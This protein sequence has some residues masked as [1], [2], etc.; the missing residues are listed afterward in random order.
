MKDMDGTDG[1]EFVV[2]LR[3]KCDRLGVRLRSHSGSRSR[4]PVPDNFTRAHP[5]L[6]ATAVGG[7]LKNVCSHLAAA[8]FICFAPWVWRSHIRL[9][10]VRVQKVTLAQETPA[11]KFLPA[12]PGPHPVA[13]PAHGGSGNSCWI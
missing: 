7:E 8:C 5:E 1:E 6:A 3:M 12:V 2:R 10:L 4:N 13:L 9:S 11:L